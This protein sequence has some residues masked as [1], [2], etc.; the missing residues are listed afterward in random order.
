[1]KVPGLGKTFAHQIV[2][3]RSLAGKFA[4]VNDA[5]P[6]NKDGSIKKGLDCVLPFVTVREKRVVSP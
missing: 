1:M 4:A 3:Q 6:K 5:L 2:H